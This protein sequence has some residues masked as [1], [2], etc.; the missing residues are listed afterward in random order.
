MRE[1]RLEIHPFPLL[2]ILIL[3][4]HKQVNEHGTL[5]FEGHIAVEN[6]ETC[7]ALALQD[8]L[9]AK[10]NIID[11]NEKEETF[12]C[13]VVSSLEVHSSG[14]LKILSGTIKTGSYLMDY[15][16]HI[17]SFQSPEKTYEDIIAILQSSYQDT[18][19]IFTE[20]HGKNISNFILQYMETDWEFAKRLASQIHTVLVPD[21]KIGGVRYSFGIP[22]TNDIADIHTNFYT[23]K[24]NVGQ[25]LTDQG[26]GLE[27]KNEI[28][29]ITYIYES[30]E[31]YRIGSQIKLNGKVLYVLAA[32]T[33]LIEKE[34]VHTYYLTTKSGFQV[35]RNNN[36]CLTGVSLS[37]GVVSV[38]K[39]DVKI[40]IFKD[41]NAKKSG[42]RWFPYSTV[43]ST[44]DGTGWYCMPEIGDTVRLYIPCEDENESYVISSTHLQSQ[45]RSERVN[46]DC[47]SIMNKQKKEVLFTPG[48][49]IFTNNKGMSIELS[50]QSGI[51][52][53]SDKSILISSQ[54]SIDITSISDTL[55]IT[56]PKSVTLR[57]GATQLQLKNNLT[58]TGGQVRME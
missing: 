56:A 1:R 18:A 47:K 53:K 54:T 15:L 12:F 19:V 5:Y 55:R 34:L 46:P 11:E 32:D 22:E 6:E 39:D 30:R 17:R 25:F 57:Q 52:I 20:G 38:E 28:D 14:M 29:T 26:R 31:L 33:K 3:E 8:P 50:D 43:Y 45:D 21:D 44:P 42:A 40:S 41:E 23:I 9:G 58:L 24:R 35:A 16:P 7:L 51:K 13:G 10:V 37:A 49:L 2:D 48:S 36:V 4:C 27:S